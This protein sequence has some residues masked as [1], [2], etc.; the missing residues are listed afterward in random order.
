MAENSRSQQETV[1]HSIEDQDFPSLYRSADQA[2]LSAQRRFLTLQRI[3]I[4][5]LIIGSIVAALGQLVP[6]M[7]VKWVYMACAIIVAL[8]AR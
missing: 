5:C 1:S 8:A 3:H 7:A 2:S 4:W 6:A